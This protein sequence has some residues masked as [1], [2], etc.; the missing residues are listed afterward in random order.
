MTLA[1]KFRVTL[2]ELQSLYEQDKFEVYKGETSVTN[3]YLTLNHAHVLIDEVKIKQS[4]KKLE[5]HSRHSHRSRRSKSISSSSTTSSAARMRAL[6]EAAAARESAEYERVIAE[7]EHAR[8]EREH[9][10][11]R[12]EYEKDLAILAANRKVA[13][14]NA[15]LKAIERAIEEEEIEI[16]CEIP[17]IPKVKSE[18]RTQDWVRA[19]SVTQH[20]PQESKVPVPQHNNAPRERSQT[21]RANTAAAATLQEKDRDPQF[22]PGGLFAASTP[23]RETSASYLIETLAS[24]NTQIVAGLAKQTLPKC[25]PDIFGGDPTLFHPW[26]T[27]FKA[28]ISDA[29]VFPIQEINY[30]RSFTSGEPQRLVDNYRKRQQ[31]NPSA[32]LKDLWAE[33]ERRFGSPAVITNALLERMHKTASFGENENTKLQEFADLCA[34]V[35]S[36]VAHLPGLQCLN[37]PNAVQPIAEKLPSSLRGKWEK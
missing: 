23:I 30:L 7:R 26:K 10:R 6:A 14:A 31:Q 27:A 29:E 33:L 20:P 35:E 34:D 15:K 24:S 1:E 4:N 11:E 12:A 22:T 25:H 37:F 19:N 3:Q 32:L 21:P 13:V 8:R 18:V 9:Q 17:E 36:Q 2:Q 28:M 5:T 16:R